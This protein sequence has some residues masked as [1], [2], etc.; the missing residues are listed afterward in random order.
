MLVS[1]LFVPKRQ[2]DFR[3]PEA[4]F[5]VLFYKEKRPR[6]LIS[7]P[8]IKNGV[9]L[10]HYFSFITNGHRTFIKIFEFLNPYRKS[11]LNTALI[12]WPLVRASE[13]NSVLIQHAKFNT[14]ERFM[15]GKQQRLKK[16]FLI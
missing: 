9:K 8:N 7:T 6:L 3:N 2:Q 15:S 14:I 12:Q 1:T 5:A 11:K 4:L 10:S 13:D 16:T